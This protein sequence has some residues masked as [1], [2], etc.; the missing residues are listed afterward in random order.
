MY[1]INNAIQSNEVLLI[2]NNG[3]KIGIMPKFQA[4]NIAK[5]QNLELVQIGKG[6]PPPC[7]ILDVGKLKYQ[8][9]KNKQKQKSVQ[10]KEVR[11]KINISDHD[12]NIKVNQIKKFLDKKYIVTI[13]VVL[14][15]RENAHPNLG[16]ELIDKINQK[17]G[18]FGFQ[19]KPQ[20]E[21]HSIKEV[22]RPI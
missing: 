2:D 13:R 19:S 14:Y 3:T 5:S 18:S 4:I 22:I 10:S 8:Q 6:N 17:I 15:G 9:K 16:W 21:G 12:I 1:K 11:F 20:K 7:K